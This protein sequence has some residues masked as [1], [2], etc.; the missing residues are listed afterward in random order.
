MSYLLDALRKADH[1]R[2]LG[3]VPGLET[4]PPSAAAPG[5]P[6]WVVWVIVGIVLLNITV[7]GLILGQWLGM[8]FDLKSNT[9][10]AVHPAVQTKHQ[11]YPATDEHIGK[12]GKEKPVPKQAGHADQSQTG[13]PRDGATT[14]ASLRGNLQGTPVMDAESKA[15]M[16]DRANSVAPQPPQREKAPMLLALP[17]HVR[18]GLPEYT[19]NGHLYSSEP[20][21]SF[22]LINGG[23]YHEGS[24]LPRGGMVVAID[25][26]GVVIR[27]QGQRFRL[28]VPH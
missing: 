23:R 18:A 8:P 16:T 11:K 4:V 24:R 3:T 14:A 1:Q 20:G 9:A 25:A 22:V 2:Q 27:Y 19:V 6:A 17:E 13:D 26:E 10:V 5:T 21:L 28:P 12:K 7:L 15:E